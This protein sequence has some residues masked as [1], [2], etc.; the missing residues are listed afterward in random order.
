MTELRKSPNDITTR[1]HGRVDPVFA[2]VPLF[3][4][5]S[6]QL[7]YCAVTAELVVVVVLGSPKNDH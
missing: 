3:G 4:G 6:S 5:A 2:T 7:P 1:Q